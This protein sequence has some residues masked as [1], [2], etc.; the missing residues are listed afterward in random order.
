MPNTHTPPHKPLNYVLDDLPLSPA[1]C[2]IL[3]QQLCRRR[4]ETGTEERE[5]ERERKE[6]WQQGKR[7]EMN[8]GRKEGRGEK[9]IKKTGKEEVGIKINKWRK[10][11]MEED[12]EQVKK[13]KNLIKAPMNINLMQLGHFLSLSFLV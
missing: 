10:R 8:K 1:A 11:K 7:K 2:P 4:R 3:G 13:T 6:W 12:Y 9:D 5:G